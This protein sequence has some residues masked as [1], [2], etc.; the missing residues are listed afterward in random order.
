MIKNKLKK[1]VF[2]IISVLII[3]LIISVYP[4]K[5]EIKIVNENKKKLNY[6]YLL[7]DQNYLSRVE[8]LLKNENEINKIY[9]IIEYL[10]I[11]SKKNNYIKEGFNPIIPKHTK[12]KNIE[13]DNQIISLNFSKELL[14][15]NNNQ[16]EQLISAIVY[17][18]TSLNKSYKVSIKIN[19]KLLTS[20]NNTII[21]SL[22]DRNYGINKEYDLNKINGTNLTTVY[23]LS[24][25][26]NYYY[27]VPITYIN[28]N[29]D[30]LKI[31][32]EEMASKTI[33]KTNL[34]SY[35]KQTSN[36]E[37]NSNED[38][39][40]IN[41]NQ[42]NFNNENTIEELIYTINLSLEENFNEKNIIYN[43]NNKL[44]KKIK[45]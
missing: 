31:I 39:I 28:N 44:Y 35:L 5:K 36:I 3:I 17:S 6:I 14:N 45:I 41:I 12:L 34:I 18:I 10:T 9:E 16:I 13:I 8:I 25:N 37:Y 1:K 21:P 15:I 23:Y 43:I 38:N 32:I 24:K 26:N 29:K 20:I 2:I 40:I 11:D 7:N 33:Y 27:Y 42:N 4:P 19:G 30:K 22:I